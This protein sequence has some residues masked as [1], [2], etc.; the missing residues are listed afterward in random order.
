MS[1]DGPARYRFGPLERKGVVAGLSPGQAL[2]LGGGLVVAVGLLRALSSVAGVIP[3]VGAVGLA[4]ALAFVPVAGRT[5]EEW[6]PVVVRYGRRRLRGGRVQLDRS[7]RQGST[8]D[9]PEPPAALRRSRVR[10]FTPEGHSPE[11]GVFV[12]ASTGLHSAVLSAGGGGFALLDAGE[13]ARRLAAWSAVLAGLARDGSVVSR[14]QWVERVRPSSQ[15]SL[16]FA[17]AERLDPDAPE[18]ASDSYERLVAAAGPATPRHEAFVALAVAPHRAR[19]QWRAAGGGDDGAARLLLREIAL[20]EANLRAAEV[21]V[22]APLGPV[23][24]AAALAGGFHGG[25]G[26]WRSPWPTAVESSWDAVRTDSCWHA[27]YWVAQWPLTEVPPDFLVP[28]MLMVPSVRTVSVTMEPV[29]PRRAA[30]EVEAALTSGAADDELRRRVGFLTTARRRRQAAGTAQREQEMADGHADV[31]FS[32][33]VSVAAADRTQ[34][35]TACAEVEH[36][37]AQA[38]LELRRLY[39]QQEEALTFT[40]PIGRGLR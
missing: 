38:R 26:H 5:A 16:S 4:L 20:L 3:A 33:Y 6:V 13:K 35:E 18:S 12:D 2:C 23:A 37:A 30:R 22:S 11:V 1:E 32:G 39:G 36:A 19:R 27:T 10:S 24:L 34:L 8:G 21:E 15:D 31:R 7:H 17:A 14:I 25:R 40:L 29:D 9:G 28:L